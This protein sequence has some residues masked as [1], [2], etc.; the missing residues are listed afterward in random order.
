MGISSE[1]GLGKPRT[2]RFSAPVVMTLAGSM[3]QVLPPFIRQRFERSDAPMSPVGLDG[4]D[5]WSG[6]G[7]DKDELA[8][9]VDTACSTTTGIP[10][11]PQYFPRRKWLWSQWDGTIVRRVLPKDVLFNCVFAA[12]VGVGLRAVPLNGSV[13]AARMASDLAQIQKVWTLAATMVSFTLSFFLS[14]S[15]N[16]WRQVYS[17]TRRVQG[18]LNDLGLLSATYAQRDPET[19]R[20]TREAEMTLKT[21]ARY[22]RLF[23]YLF[24]ASVSTRFAPLKTPQGLSAL[25]A[26]GALTSDERDVLLES[27]MG[28]NAVVEWLSLLFDT[29]VADGRLGVT[30]SRYSGTSPIAV[31]MSLQ[32]KV[33]EL[34]QTYA[35]I[36]DELAGRM[37]LAYVQL[38]QIL[39]DLLIF[40]TPFALVSSVGGFGAVCGTAI[41]TLFHSSIV[42]L[43]K[44]FLDPFSNELDQRGGDA[45]VGGI[46]VATLLQE[47]NVGSE[48]WRRSASLVPLAAW[49]PPDIPEKIEQTFVQRIFGGGAAEPGDDA[50]GDVVGSSQEAASIAVASSGAMSV[51]DDALGAGSDV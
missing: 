49:H 50:R 37:P 34:R 23:S 26:T 1:L 14:Q 40:F 42:N 4:G 16:M 10:I 9:V 15:Y 32:N 47:T 5:I 25:V 18:R 12:A 7:M 45:G 48:R 3:R 31:Q 13:G 6:F 21:V 36:P 35:A 33:V 20:Y 43:A 11:I 41:V 8:E 51:D 19:G 27:S 29:S 44:A 39:S 46:S 24:Y 28:H 17:L 22:V 2:M 30:V 38:V